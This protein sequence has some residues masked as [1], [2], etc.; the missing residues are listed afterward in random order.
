MDIEKVVVVK[1][2]SLED[3]VRLA[4]ALSAPQMTTYL[5]RFLDKDKM[6]IGL[7]G[8]FRDYYKYYGIPVFYYYVLEGDVVESVKDANYII[9]SID[10]DKIEF[11]RKPKPGLSIPLIT[12]AEKPD[13][14][15]EL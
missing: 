11:S 2:N 1:M 14:I 9:I 3:L 12:L 7:L 6:V 13:I 5:I 8:V 4:T 10:E 15:P